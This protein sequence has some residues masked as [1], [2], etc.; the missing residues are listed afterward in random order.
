[1]K[2]L[3]ITATFPKLSETFILNEI[4]ELIRLGHDVRIYAHTNENKKVH[5]DVH[6]YDL[7]SRTIYESSSKYR[8]GREKLLKFI[9]ESIQQPLKSI[10]YIKF[11]YKDEKEFWPL[12]DKY[13]ECKKFKFKPDIIHGC[14]ASEFHLKKAFFQ[15]YIQKAPFT[16]T[17]RA[18]EIYTKRNL[19]FLKENNNILK[20]AS[21]F[22][23]IS[24]Y[25]K[26]YVKYHFNIE[27]NITII[28]SAINLDMF[29]PSKKRKRGKIISITRF[30]EKKGLIYLIKAL[31]I[32][33]KRNI[34]YECVLAG[35]GPEEGNYKNLINEF[36]IPNIKFVGSLSRE[37]V[38]KQL[39]DSSIL[40]LPCI[41]AKD[42]NRDGLPNTL[43][44]AMAMGIPVITSNICGI[45]ELVEDNVNGILVPPKNPEAIADAIEKLIKN[46]RAGE[47]MGKAGRKK[48][49]E[50]FN[51]KV[52]TK[53][54]EKA[55]QEVIN[56]KR[57]KK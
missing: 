43:K 57:N 37:E 15:S 2:I 22:F 27:K 20:K 3:Y 8:L 55:F 40:V 33:N 32:L 36:K 23:T 50:N 48:I 7:L 18:F 28:H 26:E 6:R 29:K 49:E 9:S 44:E 16:L 56:D 39:S 14:F 54:L 38:K 12:M 47:E 41:I 21:K 13:L 53:K 42:G 17:F 24:N 11:L 30:I 25:N 52:E 5:E 31:H 45:E 51:I 35:Q 4:I 10:R 1:M 19:K 46:S 34:N